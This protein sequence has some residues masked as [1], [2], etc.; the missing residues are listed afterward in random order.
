M[1]VDIAKR[2]ADRWRVMNA[3]FDASD[4]SETV[5][6]RPGFAFKELGLT[7]REQADACNYLIGERLIRVAAKFEE[8]DLP[9]I[10]HITHRGIVEMEHSLSAPDKPTEHFPPALSVINVFGSV[11]ASTIQSGSPGA[12][13]SIIPTTAPDSEDAR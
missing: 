4:G 13:Q 5:Q 1:A 6:V 9:V 2:Q 12:R 7:E 11:T 8:S 3:I 10:V